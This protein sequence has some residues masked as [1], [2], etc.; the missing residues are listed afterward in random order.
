MQKSRC[1]ANLEVV[2]LRHELF[3]LL[4]VALL[5]P[6]DTTVVWEQKNSENQ[7]LMDANTRESGKTIR[8]HS[9]LFAV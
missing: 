7:P 9:R 5:N 1:V 2:K 6:I 4:G 3:N 8:V